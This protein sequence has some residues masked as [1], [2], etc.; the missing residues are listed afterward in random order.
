MA[1]IALEL[2][3]K[4]H[5]R[6]VV[7]DLVHGRIANEIGNGRILFLFTRS[8][9]KFVNNFVERLIAV[10]MGRQPFLQ[11]KAICPAIPRARSSQTKLPPAGC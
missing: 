1:L 5:P 8:G 4:E 11:A 6:N 7:G 2:D 9:E 3:T 10:E